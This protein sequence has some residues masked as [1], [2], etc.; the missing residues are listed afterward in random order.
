MHENHKN[1]T[2][3]LE[4]FQLYTI[5]YAP[6]NQV[7]PLSQQKLYLTYYVCVL[8]VCTHYDYVFF[9]GV[10]ACVHVCSV[11]VRFVYVCI[12]MHECGVHA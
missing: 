8:Y 9:V 1:Y 7:N 11:C 2:C 3:I 5:Q 12:S 6:A 10:C 4:Y